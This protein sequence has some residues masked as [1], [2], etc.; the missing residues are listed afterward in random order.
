MSGCG[1]PQGAKPSG[2]TGGRGSRVEPVPSVSVF[3]R[4]GRVPWPIR[5]QD[6]ASKAVRTLYLNPRIRTRAFV[7]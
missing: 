1:R 4:P 3:M 7:D 2:G 5:S 6:V